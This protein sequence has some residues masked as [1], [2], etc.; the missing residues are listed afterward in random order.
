M[1][2]QRNTR[3]AHILKSPG[4]PPNEPPS[5]MSRI[6]IVDDEELGAQA[7]VAVL[8]SLG[9]DA[10]MATSGP[11]ALARTDIGSFDVII[12]DYDMPKMNGL[13]AARKLKELGSRAG[14][15]MLSG[16]LD[17]PSS[18][19]RLIDYFISKGAGVASLTSAVQKVLKSHDA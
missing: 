16:R 18:A 7:R 19:N 13:E 12:L 8:R 6:L 17:F 1:S 9:F 14:L 15:V 10:T 3:P 2:K 5:H 4:Q 11:D